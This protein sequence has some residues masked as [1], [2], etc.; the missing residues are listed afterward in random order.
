MLAIA[1]RRFS[2][3]KKS[4]FFVLFLVGGGVLGSLQEVNA[5]VYH[6]SSL[7]ELIIG[8]DWASWYQTQT[9]ET[10]D[11][12]H[13]G[14]YVFREVNGVLYMGLGTARPAES[15]GATLASF[16][17][18]TLSAI[19]NFDEQGV[20]DMEDYNGDLYI[21]G[22]DP[23]YGDD[24]SLGNFYTYSGGTFTK[25]RSGNGLSNVIHMWGL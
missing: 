15:N 22:S 14:G 23:A 9:G 13:F 20:H 10:P 5:A 1:R 4:L 3:L 6:D 18:T 8:T 25:H 19:G 2:I 17:G 16:D 11:V 24:W 7:S 12:D 21:A